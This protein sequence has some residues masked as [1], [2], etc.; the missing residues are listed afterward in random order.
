MSADDDAIDLHS[1]LI[2]PSLDDQLNVAGLLDHV[3]SPACLLSNVG[4]INSQRQ[5]LH[6]PPSYVINDA[7]TF[8]FDSSPS[9]INDGGWDEII[10]FI[11]T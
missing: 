10:Y 7:E 9:G 5:G 8:G 2:T 3:A 1:T 4:V 6:T 11:T